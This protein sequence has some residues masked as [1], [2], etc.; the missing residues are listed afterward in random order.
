MLS[1]HDV[2]NLQR[3]LRK[4]DVLNDEEEKTVER[5]TTREDRTRCLIDTV[6]KKG[7]GASILMGDYL[8]ENY[9]TPTL[10]RIS[11]LFFKTFLLFSKEL[12]TF[13]QLSSC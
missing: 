11:E 3:Y 4:M 2:T 6:M 9:L 1:D 7:E 10:T 8:M 12:L 5:K 13:I